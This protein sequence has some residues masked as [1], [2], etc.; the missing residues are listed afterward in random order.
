VKTQTVK[1]MPAVIAS[2]PLSSALAAISSKTK[3][4]TSS[5]T[6][7]TTPPSHTTH[8]TEELVTYEILQEL[9]KERR[10]R[11]ELEEKIRQLQLEKESGKPSDNEIVLSRKHYVALQAE[12][13]GY[14]QLVEALTADRPA[15]AAAVRSTLRQKILQKQHHDHSSLLQQ[16]PSQQTVVPT[17]PSLPLHVIRLLE[18]MPWDPRAKEFAFATEAMYEWQFYNSKT[19]TWGTELRD[20][21]P[22]FRTLPTEEPKP[23]V[24][25]RGGNPKRKLSLTLWVG[26]ENVLGTSP[27]N[28]CVLTD[29][30]ITKL[31]DLQKGYPLPENGGTWQWVGGWRVEKRIDLSNDYSDELEIGTRSSEANKKSRV[32]CDDEGWS[33][34][35]EATHFLLNPAETCWDNAGDNTVLRPIRRRKWTR[36]RSLVDYPHVSESTKCFLDLM[37]QRKCA[38]MAANKVSEQLVKTK[39]A[40]TEAE[41]V[42]MQSKDELIL[43]V[44]SL[45]KDLETSKNK[46][47][48][49]CKEFK[50]T[51]QFVGYSIDKLQN[52]VLELMNSSASRQSADVGLAMS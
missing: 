41:S 21:P 5:A 45:K 19:K 31:Y 40:L 28:Q 43:Q 35:M 2:Q 18:V 29:R 3:R 42:V 14:R 46:K 34:A 12:L 33:Y 25:A 48:N 52:R 8:S 39:V 50:E 1:T 11:A 37:A 7:A 4:R 15:V 23:G 30:P 24:N 20:S 51:L 36:Q 17:P 16:R 49:S 32:D 6:T 38:T 47:I 10:L 27:P 26:A 13:Q 22:L 9:D 44:H